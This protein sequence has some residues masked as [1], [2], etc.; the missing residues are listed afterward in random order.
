MNSLFGTQLWYSALNVL[1]YSMNNRFLANEE[2]LKVANTNDVQ[3][4][5]MKAFQLMERK[6]VSQMLMGNITP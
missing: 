4:S 2:F 5:Q 6:S 3:P 1:T